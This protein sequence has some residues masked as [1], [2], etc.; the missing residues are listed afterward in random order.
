MFNTH[1]ARRAVRLLGAVAV[2]GVLSAGV[3][4]TAP[5]AALTAGPS[6]GSGYADGLTADTGTF[7]QANG[8]NGYLANGLGAAGPGPR[9]VHGWRHIQNANGL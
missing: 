9:D 7:A 4:A 5:A 8:L 6:S 3:L 1:L 2:T